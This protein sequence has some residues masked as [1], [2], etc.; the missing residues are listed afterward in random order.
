MRPVTTVLSVVAMLFLASIAQAEEPNDTTFYRLTKVD[1]FAFGG[2]GIAGVTSHGEKDF[3]VILARPTA[4]ATF[5]KLYSVGNLQAKAYALVGIHSLDVERFNYLAVT[6]PN[7]TRL[8]K[9]KVMR[10]CI[11]SDDPYE[12]ILKSIVA[13]DYEPKK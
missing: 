7:S 6:I 1:T 9:V 5:E 2:V 3:R 11:I 12:V 10:G 13:G 8:L 4:L